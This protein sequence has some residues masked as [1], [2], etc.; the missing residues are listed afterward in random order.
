[1][2]THIVVGDNQELNRIAGWQPTIAL[3][4]TLRDIPDYWGRVVQKMKTTSNVAIVH[5]WVVKLGGAER[6]LESFVNLLKPRTIFTLLA[7]PESLKHLGIKEAMVQQSFVAKLPRA[8]QWYTMYLPMFP[9]AV[10]AWDLREYDVV[11][12]SSHAVAKGV[13]T[14]QGQLHVCYCYT[15]MRYAWDLFFDY[16]PSN[17]LLRTLVQLN[18]HNLRQWDQ[19]SSSRVDYFIAISEVVARRIWATYRREA[20]VIYPPVDVDR[21]SIGV[22]KEE[23]FLFVSRL[24]KYKKPRLVVETFNQSGLPLVVIGDGPELKALQKIA[25]QNITFLGWQPD[26][27]VTHYMERAR[28][29]VYPAYEDFGIVPVEAQSAGT[30]VIA[31]NKGGVTE[32]VKDL[33]ASDSPTGILF[34]EQ[35]VQSLEGAIRTFCEHEGQFKPEALR[36]HAEQFGAQRF[37]EQI[38][39]FIGTKYRQFQGR[40]Q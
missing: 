36:R 31:F 24:V 26:D 12:S 40:K 10:E 4:D 6:C 25:K 16:L 17:R 30:S 28:A 15:P 33:G 38:T 2:A 1:M 9:H 22:K 8:L 18:M 14:T 37:A 3:S 5:D 39:H 11:L 29:L 34:E 13:L 19:F 20:E 21:F 27:T 32:T 7:D 23:F 35:T